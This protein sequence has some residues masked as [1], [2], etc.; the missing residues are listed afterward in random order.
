[1]TT[2]LFGTFELTPATGEL[3]QHGDPI[4]LA[5]QPFKVL[6]LLAGR[7]G[8]VVTRVELR[9]HLWGDTFVD[10][11]QGLNF[12]IRQIRSVLG[13]TADAPRFIETLPR[14]GYRF[15]MPVTARAAQAGGVSRQPRQPGRVTRLI[16][17]PFRML[18]PDPEI[19]F[20]AFSLPDAVTSSLSGL[21]SLVVRSS[22]AASRFAA[23]GAGTGAGMGE[24]L[25]PKAIAREADVDVIVTGTLL[26][27]GNQVRVA[28]QLTDA[29]SG[30]LL[31]SNSAQ[32]PVGEIF[33]VQ[34][35]LTHAIVA[36]LSLPLTVR[37]Q[38]MLD[39]DVPA[40]AKAYEYF[41]R[42]NQLSTDS[43]QW[44]V[45]RELYLKCVEADPHYAPAWA[46]LGRMHHVLGKYLE[47][48]TGNSDSLDR[49]EAAFRRAL[50]LNP[51]LPIAHKLFAQLEVDRGRARDAMA[52]LL[53][54]VQVA[55]ADPELLAGLVSACRYSGLLDA[56]V[57][58][59]TRA[60]TLDPTIR[61]SVPQTW[62]LQ[63]DYVRVVTARIA[64]LPYIVAVSLFE[65]GRGGEAIPLLR[66]L[67]DKRPP[68]IRD[69]I[70]VA[71][72]L[73]EGN[74]TDSIA[75][76]GRVVASDF[77]D[78]EGLFL[79]SRHLAR[80]NERS[81]A[82]AL[83]ERVI[84]GGFCCFPAMSGDP[85]FESLRTEPTFDALQREAETRYR[86]AVTFWSSSKT[87]L[88]LSQHQ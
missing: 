9:N 32:A 79:L 41:L 27:A 8:E 80:L 61:T 48:G 16:V 71:R 42:A 13:D 38:Q 33:Q 65:L 70:V 12:C 67:E 1:M 20:L 88:E 14:R 64:D 28:A 37:E 17:L 3:R 86:E 39:H 78:P 18:R 22:M 83:L 24:G 85:W 58:A 63:R 21:A 50:D 30:T 56:S 57:A 75:A 77:G 82:L 73:L 46:R 52:R 74:R 51:D 29:S 19:D 34:D 66:A 62:F 43:Q 5:P 26:R 55:D 87:H 49:A 6:E 84:A 53:A 72:T 60:A 59:H 68:R 44:S 10:Y 15:L 23:A 25:D 54:R 31:W 4:K 36:S 47:T 2:L 7:A 76:V 45:A 69:F 35:D 40:S 11:E 81:A